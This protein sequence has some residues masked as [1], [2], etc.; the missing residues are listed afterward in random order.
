MSGARNVISGNDGAGV[1]ISGSGATGNQVQGNFIGTDVTGTAPL[2]NSRPGV[3]IRSSAGNNRIGG[4]G[5]MP[6]VCDGPCNRTAFNGAAG[7]RILSGTGNTI[8]SNSIHSNGGLGIDLAT[9][10]VTANDTGDGDTGAN[11]LQNFPV[12]ASATSGSATG[13]ITIKG[14][15]NSTPNTTIT[16][17]FF[18]NA[19]GDASGHGEGQTFIGETLVT[20]DGSGNKSFTTNISVA[21][22]LGQLIT[23]TAS[24]PDNNTSEFSQCIILRVENT[25]RGSGVVV[26]PEDP[27][28]GTSPATLTFEEIEE[29]GYTS[30]GI[31]SEGLPPPSGFKL[32]DPPTYY[33]LTTTAEFSG[34]VEVCIEYDDTG[35]TR[36]QENALELFH[37]DGAW[38]EV[39]SSR[40]IIANVICG[41]ATSLSPFAIFESIAPLTINQATV[42]A[43]VALLPSGDKKADHRIEKAIEHIQQ[44]LDEKLWE[45][46]RTLTRKGK[47]VF[48]E[49]KKAVHELMKIEDPPM[50]ISDAINSLVRV[51]EL[52]A[53]TAIH[54]AVDADGDA[55]EIPKA[56]KEMD[57]VA[58]E[59]GKGHYD[60]AIEHYK[61]AWEYAQ[62]A[63]KRVPE[64]EDVAKPV[65]LTRADPERF[66]L[67]QNRPNPFNPVTTIAYN[68]PEASDVRLTIYSI[69]GQRVGI[70][71]S[72]HQAAGRYEVGWDGSRFANGVYF[73]RLEAGAFVQTQRMLLLK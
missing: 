31:S 72:A 56:Q 1:R 45:D 50:A 21:V 26:T 42:D 28:T 67:L 22:P 70:L 25:P 57:K 30:L 10:G 35:M 5:V 34:S 27:E 32:G 7:V 14:D 33:E 16:L 55:R 71:V 38:V 36:A 6:G 68:L 60:K 69:T 3:V 15:L 17:Q 73:Y 54:E 52:L 44:S 58:E 41:Q 12:L 29:G 49:E 64:P 51:G 19:I 20:T 8:L 53:Q 23:A 40:D 61:K 9:A 37:Y 18:S 66:S 48:S 59:I 65:L 62:K 11:L 43:L 4:T 39:T 24:D 13:D 63:M 46:D 47:T 2:G